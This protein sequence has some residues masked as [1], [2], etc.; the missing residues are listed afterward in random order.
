M[1][2]KTSQVCPDGRSSITYH[3]HILT[4][5][6]IYILRGKRNRLCTKF[7]ETWRSFVHFRCSSDMIVVHFML[8][9][10]DN[11]R[12]LFQFI[13]PF[14]IGRWTKLKFQSICPAQ[15]RKTIITEQISI[16]FPENVQWISITVGLKVV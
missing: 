12:G 6:N 11:L 5:Q 1:S 15:N 2:K 7:P 10:M 4:F 13:I 8:V 3:S 14:H 9:F 16:S